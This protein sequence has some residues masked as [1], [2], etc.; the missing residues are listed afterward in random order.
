MTPEFEERL[1]KAVD[2]GLLPNVVVLA[3]DKSGTPPAP[4][5]SISP[6]PPHHHH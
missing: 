4:H 3:K 5:F 1:K 6:S 2:D